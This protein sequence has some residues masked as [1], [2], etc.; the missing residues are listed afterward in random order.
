MSADGV[1]PNGVLCRSGDVTVQDDGT[2]EIDGARI[3]H[4]RWAE[5]GDE[6]DAMWSMEVVFDDAELWG[7]GAGARVVR[8]VAEYVLIEQRAARIVI[9]AGADR[10]ACASAG[11]RVEGGAIVLVADD[12][13]V[14]LT[15][16]LARIDSIN[17]A[18][19]DGAAGE[20]NVA[21]TVAA[22][23]AARGFEV[24]RDH[25]VD[26][27]ENVLLIRRAPAGATGGRSLVLNAHMDTVGVGSAA[28]AAVRLGDGRLEGRGVLDTKGGLAAAMIAAANVPAESL[29]ADLI[30][31]AV[32][33]EE[34]GSLGTD[35]LV[36]RHAL[37][38]DAA[39]VLEPTDLAIVVRHRGFAVIEVTIT[40]RA[41]H[42][43]RPDLGIN[44]VAAA[45]SIAVELALL[46][47]TWA[48]WVPPGGARSDAPSVLVNRID[49]MGELFTVPAAGSM[50]VE[51]RTTAA[52]PEREVAAV[53]ATIE[54]T[55]SCATVA[56]QVL[57]ERPPMTVPI[58]DPLVAQLASAIGDQVGT[59]PA[60]VGAPFWTDAALHRASG[61]PAVVVG[62][63]GAGLH[64][65]LEWVATDS[66]RRCARALE[67]FATG[68]L[69]GE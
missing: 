41:A 61:T 39:I 29:R 8:L 30:V 45:A 44:A 9:E 36:A 58:D 15:A 52:G 69:A 56:T 46:D 11:F 13:P 68:W 24:V 17:P 27:R 49:T 55:V 63:V 25:V 50:L 59:S 53:L 35:A 47:R 5:V 28:T 51:V 16:R 2:V 31:A 38:M 62:P 43:S 33:D 7:T 48:R 20:R 3:G 4:A 32:I 14:G 57:I 67:Q 34:H 65:D 54:R 18:L 37:G 26:G 12:D 1:D 60:L 40:G 10:A 23:G 19:V 6:A 66:L 64:E 22:W 42:T 21:D